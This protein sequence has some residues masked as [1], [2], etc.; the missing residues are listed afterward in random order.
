[1][2]SKTDTTKGLSLSQTK[3]IDCILKSEKPLK[4]HPK[5]ANLALASVLN[6]YLSYLRKTFI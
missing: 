1:M 2:W 5:I 4:T 3:I 6:A